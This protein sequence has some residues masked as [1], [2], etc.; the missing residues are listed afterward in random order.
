M[1]IKDADEI[2]KLLKAKS[3]EFKD[4]ENSEQLTGDEREKLFQLSCDCARIANEIAHLNS[5]N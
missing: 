2:V 4:M 1:T 5:T 3:I